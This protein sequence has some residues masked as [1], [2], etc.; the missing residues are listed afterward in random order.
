MHLNNRGS[1][2]ITTVIIFSIISTICIMCIGLNFSNE[3]IFNLEYKNIKLNENA[4]SGLELSQNNIFKEVD[5]AIK[6]SNN[7]YDF[8]KYIMDSNFLSN[9]KDISMSELENVSISTS[10]KVNLI[11]DEFLFDIMSSSKEN[12]YNKKY[13]AS[14][15]IINPFINT[16]SDEYINNLSYQINFKKIIIV[17]DY[18]EI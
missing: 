6:N 9:I 1:I 18:K 8:N 10:K 14:V 7:K 5:N 15:K 13:Q 11:N 17:Y 12:N 4:L 3:S 2:L 16:N